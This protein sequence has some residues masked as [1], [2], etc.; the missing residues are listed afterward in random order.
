MTNAL[1]PSPNRVLVVDND[2]SQIAEYVACLGEDFEADN[3]TDT[4]TGLEK[5][6]LGEETDVEHNPRFEVHSRNQG[7]TA[8]E[9][10]Q[11]AL[12]RKQP[13]AAVILEL[14]LPPGIGGIETAQQIRALDPYVNIVIVSGSS[15][16]NPENLGKKIAP[17][18]KVFFFRKP[19]HGVECRQLAAALCGKWHA[20][21]AL[22]LA[23]E[24]LERRVEE[25]TAALQKIAYFDVVT[26]LPNQLLLIEELKNLISTGEDKEGDTVV[27]LLDIDRFSFINETMGYDAGTELLRSI[28]NRLSRTFA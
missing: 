10:V 27:V 17:A 15:D 13:F 1:H 6:F 9:A 22:R 7:D 3:S 11:H 26:R 16:A 23:N 24:D 2:A 12:E 28:A 18:D 14:D 5:V 8:V 4:L 19:F 25:R 21:L 20:D